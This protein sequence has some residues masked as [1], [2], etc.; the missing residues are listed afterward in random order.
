M[1]VFRLCH[2]ALRRF[3]EARGILGGKFGYLGSFH[4]TILLTSLMLN[5]PELM[6]AASLI[7]AFMGTYSKWDWGGSDVEISQ[8]QQGK[9]NR[10][11]DPAVISSIHRPILN[12]WASATHSAVVTVTRE[13]SRAYRDLKQGLPW[14]Q[15]CEGTEQMTPQRA[16]LTMY[17]W[18]VKVEVNYWGRNGQKG[19]SLLGYVESRVVTVSIHF[20]LLEQQLI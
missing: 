2:R 20:C 9:Y 11:E 13:F 18:Y 12:I 16:F 6:T 10:K 1:D 19:R 8:L 14:S 15:I 5:N 3:C 4:L 7:E 17:S